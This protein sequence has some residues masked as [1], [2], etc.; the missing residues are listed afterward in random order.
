MD[1]T[2]KCLYLQWYHTF[3]ESSY[4]INFSQ[5][6]TDHKTGKSYI[7][8]GP[9]ERYQNKYTFDLKVKVDD[10]CTCIPFSTVNK[11][12]MTLFNVDT[13]SS[14]NN[15]QLK[16]IPSSLTIEIN[17]S[18]KNYI[19]FKKINKGRYYCIALKGKCLWLKFNQIRN[20]DEQPIGLV[21][22]RTQNAQQNVNKF[23][24]IRS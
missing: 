17:K 24:I 12:G 13:S 11:H 22:E 21:F 15:Q 23:I 14:R 20:Y 8:F 9:S 1:K 16:F 5:K 18:K 6:I 10:F 3:T 4:E 7:C 19:K 2:I